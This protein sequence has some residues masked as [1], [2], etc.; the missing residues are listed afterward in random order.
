M[1]SAKF[2]VRLPI[3]L[4]RFLNEWKRKI[5]YSNLNKRTKET[6]PFSVESTTTSSY[7]DL[8]QPLMSQLQKKKNP[9]FSPLTIHSPSWWYHLSWEL[10]CCD[11]FL[12]VDNVVDVWY[13]SDGIT[14]ASK[15]S[16]PYHADVTH[17]IACKRKPQELESNVS[18]IPIPAIKGFK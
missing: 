5:H 15:T 6:K 4:S 16:R 14:T 1:P 10:P 7:H 11:Q 12:Q 13:K 2:L 17:G 8:T 18:L 3:T 9:L